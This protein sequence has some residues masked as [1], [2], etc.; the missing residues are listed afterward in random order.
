VCDSDHH[1]LKVQ[2]GAPLLAPVALQLKHQSWV[3]N[4]RHFVAHSAEN[5]CEKC[6]MKNGNPKANTKPYKKKMGVR[7]SPP[8]G[9]GNIS[10]KP[11]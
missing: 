8:N 7:Q 4:G 10:K 11:G 6:Q 2:H 5:I 9:S 3:V 1:T